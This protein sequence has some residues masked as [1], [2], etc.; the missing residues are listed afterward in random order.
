MP[1][2]VYSPLK[3]CVGYQKVEFM[4]VL[5]HRLKAVALQEQVAA[6]PELKRPFVLSSTLTELSR[7][8]S[9]P[10]PRYSV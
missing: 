7:S 4:P 2:V 6:L 5:G 10:S 3:R 8:L 1:G 9:H